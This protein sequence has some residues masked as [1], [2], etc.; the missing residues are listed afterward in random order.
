MSGSE[1][2]GGLK[3]KQRNK[4]QKEPCI[5]LLVIDAIMVE[6]FEG[7]CKEGEEW[8]VFFIMFRSLLHKINDPVED[9]E[10]VKV[11]S[12]NHRAQNKV[13]ITDELNISAVFFIEH[14]I[15]HIT[16]AE[17]SGEFVFWVTG[18][19]NDHWNFAEFAGVDRADLWLVAVF[20]FSQYD[21]PG[22]DDHGFS[23][24]VSGNIIIYVNPSCH[25]AYGLFK[26]CTDGEQ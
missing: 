7:S 4:S 21:S 12:G 2:K 22:F 8:E 13:T 5:K 9:S 26:Q 19:F 6:F 23:F 11:R 14:Q 20:C 24:F 16:S 25:K 3:A 17:Q 15:D 10:S 18:T 1:T